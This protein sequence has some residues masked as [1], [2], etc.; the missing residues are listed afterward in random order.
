MRIDEDSEEDIPKKKP[1]PKPE[2]KSEQTSKPAEP[3][4]TELPKKEHR[5]EVKKEYDMKQEELPKQKP[6]SKEQVKPKDPQPVQKRPDSSKDRDQKMKIEEKDIKVKEEEK[7]DKKK[8]LDI[9]RNE[10]N[11]NSKKIQKPESPKKPLVKKDDRIKAKA[12]ANGIK[13][14]KKRKRK[15]DDDDDAEV[16]L[17]GQKYSTP[18]DDDPSRAFYY[19]LYEQNPKSMM[20]LKWCLEYGLLDPDTAAELSKKAGKFKED[21]SKKK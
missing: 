21:K 7:D 3:K 12:E 18:S 4:K 19:S 9:S 13:P 14:P 8:K 15:D 20:A 5:D 2:P 16:F 11:K 1:E 10:L 6:V 17:P